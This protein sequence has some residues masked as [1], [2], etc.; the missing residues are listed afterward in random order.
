MRES[1]ADYKQAMHL[2]SPENTSDAWTPRI[3]SA[4]GIDVDSVNQLHGIVDEYFRHIQLKGI[5]SDQRQAQWQT[6]FEDSLGWAVREVL[7]ERGLNTSAYYPEAS[8]L[9]PAKAYDLIRQ[10]FS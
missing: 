5:Y 10:K 9:P 2:S 4:S 1:I 7:Q 3:E 8:E 6:W